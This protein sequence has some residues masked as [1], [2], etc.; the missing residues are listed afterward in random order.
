MVL[1]ESV[2]RC[3]WVGCL[4]VLVDCV[5]SRCCC[6]VGSVPAE[7]LL[8][9]WLPRRR[10]Q[11]GDTARDYVGNVSRVVP[12]VVSAALLGWE[13]RL[14]D[15]AGTEHA[16]CSGWWCVPDGPPSIGLCALISGVAPPRPRHQGGR[17]GAAAPKLEG[18]RW[19]QTR[20]AKWVQ[21]ASLSGASAEG[22]GG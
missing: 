12:R 5:A 9:S 8:M 6:A 18:K 20:H 14:R 19:L 15:V 1:L 13:G 21:S 10:Y 16:R 4:A 11:V 17:V 3:W 22:R 7:S 2:C